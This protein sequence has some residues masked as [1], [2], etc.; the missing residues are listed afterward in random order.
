MVNLSRR[1]RKGARELVYA[2]DEIVQCRCDGFDE[3][4]EIDSEGK[5][6][7]GGNAIVYRCRRQSS[8]EEYAIKIQVVN[9]A[10]QNARFER[11]VEVLKAVHHGQLMSCIASGEIMMR[12][13]KQRQKYPFLIMPSAEQN[14]SDFL[15][16]N[17]IPA[18]EFLF[19]QFCGL[20]EALSELHCFAV[21]RDIKPENVLIRGATWILSDFGLCKLVADSKPS[22][23]VTMNDE[24][25]GPIYWMSPESMNRILKNGD[26]ITKASDV[27]QLAAVFWFAATGRHP[28]GIV[29]RSD[30][31]GPTSLFEV[32]SDALAHSPSSR[33]KDGSEFHER[34]KDAVRHA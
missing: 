27:F 4:F 30:W 17:A 20:S 7:E 3:Q 13:G 28:T 14:M 5:L 1:R 2:V 21:H 31:H 29:S 11:E 22:K 6:G 19:G 32:L 25:I 8:G 26:E 16:C 24:K 10:K 18:Q 15:R 12:L 33:P 23:D 9:G 34:I